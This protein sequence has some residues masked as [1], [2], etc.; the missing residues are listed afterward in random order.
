MSLL[1]NIQLP[2]FEGLQPI[3]NFIGKTCEFAIHHPFLFGGGTL[4]AAFL[5]IGLVQVMAETSKQFWT[6][7]RDLSVKVV[8]FILKAFIA[9]AF[10]KP[11]QA[12]REMLKKEKQA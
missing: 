12:I 4:T 2:S 10:I 6:K 11:Y 9:I 1:P 5:S 7:I 8:K 3:I